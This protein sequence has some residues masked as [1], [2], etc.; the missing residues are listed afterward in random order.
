MLHSAHL[1]IC[2][3][4]EV[5]ILIIRVVDIVTGTQGGTK[6]SILT[7]ERPRFQTT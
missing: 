1:R 2:N 7:L 6:L 4:G 3:F 5:V